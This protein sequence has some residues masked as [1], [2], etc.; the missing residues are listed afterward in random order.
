MT[1]TEIRPFIFLVT[2]TLLYL[3]QKVVPLFKMKDHARI[4]HN[5]YVFVLSVLLLRVF[6][7]KGIMS[8]GIINF[9]YTEGLNSL[10]FGVDL[11][12]TLFIFDFAIYLQ[13][14]ATHH[15]NFLWRF[16][17]VHHSDQEMDTT[18]A[19]RFHPIEILLSAL[20]K[21]LLIIVLR[22]R[23][24]TF[25]IYEITLNAFALFNHSNLRLPKKLDQILRTLFVTPAM[26]YPHH[27]TENKLMNMNFGNIFSLWDKIFNTYT[28]QENKIFGI[29]EF[30]KKLTV[31]D[32]LFMPFR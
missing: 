3:L 16:H 8:N 9:G 12:A 19:L 31:K 30:Q 27:S 2:F 11:M 32:V 28:S 17:K 14:R 4:I 7:P 26:H 15:F 1:I 24:E 25:I 23:V 6:F 22:P 18:S 29:K 13:H 10:T 21:T 5:W 20:Y